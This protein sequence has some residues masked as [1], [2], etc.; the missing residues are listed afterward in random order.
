M[1][2]QLI[3]AVC[4]VK[5]TSVQTDIHVGRVFSYVPMLVSVICG[6][7]TIAQPIGDDSWL[8]AAP[9]TGHGAVREVPPY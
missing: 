5:M 2:K 8:S 9:S 6:G 3:Y 1:E 7:N 4:L